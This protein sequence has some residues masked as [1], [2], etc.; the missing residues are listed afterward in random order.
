M[1][2]QGALM[3]GKKEETQMEDI[4]KIWDGRKTERVQNP[5]KGNRKEDL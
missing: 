1:D 3:I 2:D 4:E 5:R